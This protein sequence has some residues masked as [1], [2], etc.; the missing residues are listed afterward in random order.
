LENKIYKVSRNRTM[1]CWPNGPLLSIL[2]PSQQTRCRKR[3]KGWLWSAPSTFQPSTTGCG[4][5]L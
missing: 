3:N 5:W 1:R 2:R 4:W